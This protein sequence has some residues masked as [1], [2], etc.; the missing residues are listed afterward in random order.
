MPSFRL[1]T[2]E[3]NGDDRGVSRGRNTWQGAARSRTSNLKAARARLYQ[4]RRQIALLFILALALLVWFA[5]P[6]REWG[7]KPA[8]VELGTSPLRPVLSGAGAKDGP[9]PIRW[10]QENSDNKWSVSN[11]A[12]GGAGQPNKPKAAL[13][14]LVRNQELEGIVQSM[15]QLEYH[16]NHKYQYPWI[17]FNDEPF[18]DEFKVRRFPLSS[19]PLTHCSVQR[20]T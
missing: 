5:P 3:P 1:P 10:L 7:A 18:N 12:F 16:W 17:F 6:P 14:S 13:I 11:R 20:K 15:T 4:A 19:V 8:V 9:D 2:P